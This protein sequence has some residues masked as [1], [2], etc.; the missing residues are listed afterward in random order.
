MTAVIAREMLEEKEILIK[1]IDVAFNKIID[2]RKYIRY[3]YG[4]SKDS[5][6]QKLN[7][8][9]MEYLNQAAWFCQYAMD[10]LNTVGNP[11]S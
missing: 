1:N 8:N 6:T 9:V 7:F 5:T 2:T 10:M 4:E 11:V 3:M